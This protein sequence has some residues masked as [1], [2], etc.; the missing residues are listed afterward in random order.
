[1][2]VLSMRSNDVSQSYWDLMERV[3]LNR[4]TNLLSYVILK[5]TAILMTKL[6][7]DESEY[8]ERKRMLLLE[9]ICEC[10][11]NIGLNI[12]EILEQVK[13]S[14]L[15]NGYS[16]KVCKIKALSR[17]LVGTKGSFGEI[18]FEIGLSFDSI[19]N[20]PFI[21]GSSLKGAFSHALEILLEKNGKSINEAKKL[22]EIV[23]GSE[24]WS[25]LIGVSD[26]Y[27]VEPGVNG[28]L[29]EPD[30]VTPHYPGAETEFDVSPNPVPF[31]T[32]ARGVVFEFYIYFNKEIY[33]EEF[34]QLGRRAKRKQAKLGIVDIE[35]LIKDGSRAC[36]LDNAIFAGDLAEAVR[37]LKARGRDAAS[38]IPCVDRAILYAFARGVGAKTNVGYS[39]FEIIEY[40]SVEG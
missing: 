19:L 3:S 24:E 34:K 23:F 35:D 1:M 4:N 27:P 22:V 40:R 8:A 9:E 39:R 15:L 20:V 30:V 26:A 5:G 17:G 14:L 31:L 7:G 32:V 33:Q 38:I 6:K 29:F 36:P 16:V 18:P 37:V 11:K 21:P 10:S 2:K 28:F 25:G 13:D 12:K